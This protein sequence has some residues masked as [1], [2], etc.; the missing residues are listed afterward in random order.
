MSKDRR[1][2]FES[3]KHKENILSQQ[4]KEDKEKTPQTYY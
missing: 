1:K 3:K 4:Q 2:L